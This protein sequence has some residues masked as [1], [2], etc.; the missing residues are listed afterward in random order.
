MKI[1]KL[2][3]IMETI[4]K[5][6]AL[7]LLVSSSVYVNSQNNPDSLSEELS[8]LKGRIEAID[9]RVLL[10][11][12]DL[13]KLT[14]I[15]VSGYIQAQFEDYQTDLVKTG[16][17]YNTFYIRRARIKFTYE[18]SDGVKFVL[19][20]D[21]ITGSFSLKDAYAIVNL[22]G[23]KDL[24]LWAGQFNR[25]NYEV[26]YSSSQREVLERSRL[27]RTIYPGEREIGLKLEYN[28]SQT[29]LKLQIA[30]VN[31][32]FTGTQAKDIDT[33]KDL[34]GRV[35]YSF[36]IP[37]VGIGIDL[38]AHGYYGGLR[39]KTKYVSNF[40]N[41]LDS[42]NVGSYL[43]KKWFGAEMQLFF[44]FLGGVS[45]K[46]EYI[47]GKN[48]F[49]GDSKTNPYKTRNF[50][51][52][53]AYLIKNL[54]VK[55]QLVAKYDNFDPNSKLSGDAAGSDVKYNTLT[56]AW[57]YYI[58]D[59]IRLTVNYEMPKNETNSNVTTDL[60]DNVFGVRIQA[61]F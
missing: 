41:E 17:P 11:E 5:F 31:G 2:T 51:G 26:E 18:A 44:D 49:I 10:N 58:N 45:L 39:A 52:Y 38:G 60:R 14:K 4:K 21:L 16:S 46:G 34:M 48:A 6:I 15:K 20:P 7:L 27:I 50:S 3:K 56:L 9:E 23:F 59:N 13:N 53:Y 28:P 12:G 19:Q 35:V 36:M 57:Q 30:M 37:D 1:L 47:L 8:A 42:V 24:S 40:D 29:P 25:P 55:H 61:K 22:P 54:G 33:K 32:N 43:D